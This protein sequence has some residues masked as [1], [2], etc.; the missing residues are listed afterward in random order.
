MVVAAAS[1]SS[2][3]VAWLLPARG[4]AGVAGRLLARGLS[5]AGVVVGSVAWWGERD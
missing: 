2:Y 5:C 3:A 1:S 4:A